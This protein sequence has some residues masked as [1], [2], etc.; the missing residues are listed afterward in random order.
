VTVPVWIPKPKPL[1]KIETGPRIPARILRYAG[2]AVST[3]KFHAGPY[4]YPRGW[5]YHRWSFGERLP[6]AFFLSRYWIAEYGQ[7]GLIEPPRGYVWVRV[8][9]DAMLVNMD[10]GEVLRSVRDI[11][12]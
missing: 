11:F 5:F 7:L 2:S 6:T 12:Y 9:S 3:R 10:N 8:D 4:L 1:P